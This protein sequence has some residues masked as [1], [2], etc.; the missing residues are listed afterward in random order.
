MKTDLSGRVA[1]VMGGTRGI[2]RAIALKLAENGAQVVFQGRDEQAAEEVIAACEQ[3]GARPTFVGA[4]IERYDEIAR[5][6]DV[7]S[8]RFGRVDIAIAN[9]GTGQPRPA[10][11]QDVPPDRI[12]GYFEGRVYSRIYMVHAAFARMQAQN[13]GKIIMVTT[14]AGRI[15][16]PSESLIGAGAAAL[17]F[18]T[19]ALGREFA[20]W[21]VRINTISTTLTRDTPPYDRYRRAAE[22]GSDAVIVKAFRK[23]EER[24]P[25]GL[26]R[27]EDLA[28]LALYLASPE[29]DQLSGATISLNGGISF[30]SYA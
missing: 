19:R 13:Y 17:I 27:P 12:A 15:P 14:D 10:L 22:Q 21:G 7:A 3:V 23:I 29:S 4:S 16:T 8:E 28:D 5:C 24:A 6:F 11:F 2:G 26:N 25:F 20:R 18:L 1:V 30:P 9:G